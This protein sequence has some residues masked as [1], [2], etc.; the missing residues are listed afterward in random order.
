VRETEAVLAAMAGA[1]EVRRYPNMPHTINEEELGACRR[2][3]GA[4]VA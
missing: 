1:V 2:L 3:I 4:L